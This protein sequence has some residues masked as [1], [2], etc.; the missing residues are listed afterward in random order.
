MASVTPADVGPYLDLESQFWQAVSAAITTV[1]HADKSLVEQY[2]ARLGS[3]S[4]YERLLALHDD[5]LDVAAMLANVTITNE[6]RARYDE[7]QSL[8]YEKPAANSQHLPTTNF[9]ITQEGLAELLKTLGYVPVNGSA[10]QRTIIWERPEYEDDTQ[11]NLPRLITIQA[12]NFHSDE[13]PEPVYDR[14]YVIDLLMS[15][16][17]T[18]LWRAL[19]AAIMRGSEARPDLERFGKR[20]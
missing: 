15:L 4:P 6:I 2:R 1:L 13:F 10:Q 5:P 16:G 8:L 17:G 11:V 18:S 12:P 3:S 7:M 19:R 14:H 9:P 20:N